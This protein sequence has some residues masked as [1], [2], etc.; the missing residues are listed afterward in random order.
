MDDF[1]A[2]PRSWLPPLLVAMPVLMALTYW[3][4]GLA[5]FLVIT[6]IIALVYIHFEAL[7]VEAPKGQDHM[8]RNPGK[9]S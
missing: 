7:P 4:F 1:R 3:L 2:K 6:G 9:G 5:A 8:T